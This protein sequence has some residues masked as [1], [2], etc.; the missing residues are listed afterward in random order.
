M[1]CPGDLNIIRRGNALLRSIPKEFGNCE[2]ILGPGTNAG[3]Q[4]GFPK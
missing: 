3:Y 4:V 1:E 2:I